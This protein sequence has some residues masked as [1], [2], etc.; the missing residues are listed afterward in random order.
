M[1]ARYIEMDTSSVERPKVG[2]DLYANRTAVVETLRQR[3]EVSILLQGYNRLEKTRR[4]VESVLKYTSPVDY[5]LILIDNGSSDGTAEYFRSVPYEKKTVI[6][7]TH[8]AGVTYPSLFL[9]LGD[10]GAYISIVH[11]DLIVTENWMSNLLTCLK[12]DSRIG[13]VNPLSSNTS[14][15]QSVELD[16]SGWENMQRKAAQFNHSDPRKWEDRQRLITLGTL[17]RKEALLAIGWPSNDVGYFHD[18][19]DDDVTF[20]IRRAGYRTVLAGDTW[21]CHD[22]DLKHGEGKD[23]EEFRQSLRIGQQNFRDK[24]YGVDA[25]ED[26]NNFYIPYF[27][28]FPAPKRQPRYT[29]LGVDVRCGTPIL[30][31]KNWLRRYEGFQTELSAFTQDPKYWLDLKTICA[32][33]VICDREEFLTD[34]FPPEHFDYVVIDR[35]VN[36]YH[37]PGKVLRDVFHLCKPG[38][39]VVCKLANAYSFREYLYLLGQEDVYNPDFSYNLPKARFQEELARYGTTCV[40]ISIGL[41]IEPQSQKLLSSL[42]PAGL[43]SEQKNR[44]LRHMQQQ[45][46]LYVVEKRA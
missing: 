13:M 33:P 30:D 43:P 12:S 27:K 25:W 26:V 31:V 39:Y 6:H 14:N 10:L 11:N 1:E 7:V 2:E 15:F 37:E 36:R 5:E 46:F 41:G 9:S 21:I 20:Q 23:P 4:C 29:I 40:E 8:N 17:Y 16:A 44:A 19:S 42:Y 28:H 35:P 32:G 3:A 38:G 18:F 45:D 24:Y 22:H 34:S